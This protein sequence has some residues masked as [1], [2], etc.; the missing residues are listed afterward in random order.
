M[1]NTN[2]F[3]S[4]IA[5]SFAY[6]QKQPTTLA[7]VLYLAGMILPCVKGPDGNT[8]TGL[9]M[10]LAVMR[11]TWIGFIMLLL[12]H[13]AVINGLA[14]VRRILPSTPATNRYA[15][16]AVGLSCALAIYWW[17]KF[18]WSLYVGFYG[19]LA[20]IVMLAFALWGPLQNK[21][22]GV[23][24]ASDPNPWLALKKPVPIALAVCLLALPLIRGAATGWGGAADSSDTRI[25]SSDSS[26]ASASDADNS[27][28][29][30]RPSGEDDPDG[31]KRVARLRAVADGTIA[32]DDF[33]RGRAIALLRS[34]D[35]AVSA[36]SESV[37]D[38]STSLSGVSPNRRVFS[39][40]EWEAI[41]ASLVREGR[42]RRT[43]LQDA[44][45]YFGIYAAIKGVFVDSGIE[46]P[47]VRMLNGFK[48][49]VCEGTITARG[50][51]AAAKQLVELVLAAKQ[52]GIPL[53]SAESAA[54]FEAG[55]VTASVPRTNG[56]TP[57]QQASG[58]TP[59]TAAQFEGTCAKCGY[60]TGRQ[61]NQSHRNCSQLGV[62]TDGT[63]P[64]GGVIIW[65]QAGGASPLQAA[66]HMPSSMQQY[67]GQCTRCGSR[68]GRQ[69]SQSQRTCSQL[70]VG[71]DGTRPCGGV[72]AWAP[73]GA[74]PGAA[75]GTA[76]PM[77][78]RQIGSGYT[79]SRM[80]QFEGQCS[81]C[82]YRTGR[83]VNQSQR[84]CS[85]L[86]VGVDGT[87]PCG[88]VIV[89]GPAQGF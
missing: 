73:A 12:A 1:V 17:V 30:L 9:G 84:T 15:L 19:W 5:R 58:Y 8:Y 80:Q 85:Q 7:F 35:S 83:Q 20:S 65:A 26:G 18:P 16:A 21:T 49:Q 61:V 10:T 38:S 33:V 50:P 82:G 87:R 81:R 23:N 11:E 53:V 74:M 75:P 86:G 72:I 44:S 66:G 64:C 69:V 78:S 14:R 47:T 45:K 43:R 25:A 52:S 27:L 22:T 60:R 62:G 2:V 54:K 34:I 32:A 77:S 29:L 55:L 88:G 63:R 37:A 71:V 28:S 4:C 67:E 3:L 59:H 13:G 68:T 51:E 46:S 89:W 76:G 70:G 36:D 57:S 6:A 79:P 39:D 31:S 24:E 41:T 40:D 48:E 42:V 56:L